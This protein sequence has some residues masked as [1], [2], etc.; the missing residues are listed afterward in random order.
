VIVIKQG[1]VLLQNV[2][3]TLAVNITCRLK[4]TQENV[5]TTDAIKMIVF[6]AG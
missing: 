1:A 5:A 3:H 2:K 6:A 4:K